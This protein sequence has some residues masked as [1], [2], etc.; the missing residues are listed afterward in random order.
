MDLS[1]DDL[2]LL[3]TALTEYLESVLP[4]VGRHFLAGSDQVDHIKVRA[5]VLRA[6]L[7]HETK[8]LNLEA[9]QEKEPA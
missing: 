2:A 4:S 8:R 9:A 7:A 3:R 1:T 6:K 5:I